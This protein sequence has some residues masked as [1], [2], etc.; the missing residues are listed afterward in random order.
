[1]SESTL[2]SSRGRLTLIILLVLLFVLFNVVSRPYEFWQRNSTPDFY[3]LIFKNGYSSD[4]IEGTNAVEKNKSDVNGPLASYSIQK[5]SDGNSEWSW[6]DTSG[7]S[8]VRLHGNPSKCKD[9]IYT[10]DT[11]LPLLP[12]LK[13]KDSFV[14][15]AWEILS[16]IVHLSPAMAETCLVFFQISTP[17]IDI[18]TNQTLHPVWGRVPAT[19]LMM[20]YFGRANYFLYMDSDAV[21]ATPNYTPTAMYHILA[22]EKYL[23]NVTS[24]QKNPGLIAN[25]PMTGWLCM[26]CELFGLG[27]GCFNSGALLWRRSLKAKIILHAWWDSRCD[28]VTQN[29]F[30]TGN[31]GEVE[32]MFGWSMPEQFGSDPLHPMGEQNRLMYIYAAYSKVRDSIWPVP[33]EVSDDSQSESCPNAL[34]DKHLPCLQ[35]DAI[36]E[37]KWN[38]SGEPT[39][40]IYHYTNKKTALDDVLEMVLLSFQNNT[41]DIP[42][43][44]VPIAKPGGIL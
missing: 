40:F 42:P 14:H 31:D 32:P 43:Q 27:H 41:S 30:R 36:T 11:R 39:C 17:F 25:K 4:G 37:V 3:S 34:D 22:N 28:N 2:Q 8:I 20:Q 10:G 16:H 35:H 29:V 23:Q 13:E 1:M 19:A 15:A 7:I 44:V 33:R 5:K 18:I 21:L 12:E 38:P 9:V 24:Q 26:Q 6:M